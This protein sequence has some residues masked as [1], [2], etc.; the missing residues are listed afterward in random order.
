MQGKLS[1]IKSK[2]RREEYWMEL[3]NDA[4][5]LLIK[6][7]FPSV[8]QMSGNQLIFSQ[9]EATVFDVLRFVSEKKIVLL[10]M[11]R[12]EPTLETLFMEVTEK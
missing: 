7:A 8:R 1:E 2:Y 10:K 3:E 12:S 9:G 6:Q 5:T 4:D 11:V